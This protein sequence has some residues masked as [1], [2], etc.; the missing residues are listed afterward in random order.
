MSGVLSRTSSGL[1]LSLLFIHQELQV[2]AV[3]FHPEHKKKGEGATRRRETTRRDNNKKGDCYFR[4]ALLR[5]SGPVN[6]KPLVFASPSFNLHPGSRVFAF[7]M[8]ATLQMAQFNVVDNVHCPE[9]ELWDLK[10]VCVFSPLLQLPQGTFTQMGHLSIS[11]TGQLVQEYLSRFSEIPV[12]ERGR[13]LKSCRT[14]R[15]QC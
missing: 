5:L 2:E 15:M 9:L 14:P 8:S 10:G 13:M 12:P 6:I 7:R 3:F 4:F 1:F 11:K